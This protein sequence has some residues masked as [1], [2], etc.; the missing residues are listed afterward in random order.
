[1]TEDGHYVAKEAQ[2]RRQAYVASRQ[3]NKIV[4]AVPVAPMETVELLKHDV[5]DVV[6]L[7]ASGI[8]LGA[9]GAYYDDFA[10]VSDDDVI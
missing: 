2:R 1:M 3:P 6:I 7:D 9:V 10:Q 8:F 4:V 5:D